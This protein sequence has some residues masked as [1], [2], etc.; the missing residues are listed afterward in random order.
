MDRDYLDDRQFP[1]AEATGVLVISAPDERGLQK[2]LKRLDL[3]LFHGGGELAMALP[4]DKSKM[5]VFP[6]LGAG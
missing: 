5:Q 2:L 3:E 6:E 4:L 1:P